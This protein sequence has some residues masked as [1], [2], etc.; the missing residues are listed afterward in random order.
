MSPKEQRLT[1]SARKHVANTIQSVRC[2]AVLPW[3]AESKNERAVSQ[4]ASLCTLT[5]VSYVGLALR[6]AARSVTD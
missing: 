6:S 4:G 5:P 2:R 3:M 1:A